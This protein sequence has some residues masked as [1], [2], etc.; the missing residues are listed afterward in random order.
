MLN[1][2]NEAAFIEV[3]VIMLRIAHVTYNRPVTTYS[4]EDILRRASLLLQNGHVSLNERES[5]R[6]I[7]PTFHEE[8]SAL[9]VRVLSIRALYT[10]A[11][12]G[13][14]DQLQELIISVMEYDVDIACDVLDHIAVVWNVKISQ[15][16]DLAKLVDICIAAYSTTPSSNIRNVA[17]R[18]LADILEHSFQ[19]DWLEWTEITSNKFRGFGLSL[20]MRGSPDLSNAEIRITGSLLA[21]DFLNHIQQGSLEGIAEQIQAWGSM[22]SDNGRSENVSMISSIA[23]RAS[24][25]YLEGL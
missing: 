20:L 22:L 2:M 12:T 11:K 18:N 17:L 15:A 5:V 24:L 8:C 21:L 1:P 7:K 16:E 9:L 10:A 14:I 6:T 23:Q 19:F 13:H 3:A 25:N 4:E